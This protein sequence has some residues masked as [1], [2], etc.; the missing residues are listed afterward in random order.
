MTAQP[1]PEQRLVS[2]L[3]RS[4]RLRARWAEDG[5]S[6]AQR[7]RLR[8]WQA[9][10]LARTHAD[11]LRSPDFRDGAEFFLTDLY[12]PKDLTAGIDQVRHV[13]PA[14]VKVLPAAALKAI[15][16]AIELEALSE[17][18][19]ADVVTALGPGTK[20]ISATSYAR[21]YR[22]V[23]RRPDRERQI[24]LINHLGGS[25]DSLARQALISVAL[26]MLRK[27][28]ELAGFGGLYGFI[29]RAYAAFRK[30]RDGGKFMTI[31][32]DREMEVSNSIFSG[33]DS[34]L[35]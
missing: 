19:D 32:A 29:E 9:E 30:M 35:G 16:D 14:M 8:A 18:L 17:D 31:V 5:N 3:D 23:G 15:A 11:L 7:T 27:P 4:A 22:T 20:Q 13:V 34:V 6:A 25:L 1:S 10:R 26:R 28:A 21:A 24:G 33:D 2:E 12:G